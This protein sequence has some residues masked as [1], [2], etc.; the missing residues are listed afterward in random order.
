MVECAGKRFL[1][2]PP[3]PQ[4]KK[5]GGEVQT[6][7]MVRLWFDYVGLPQMPRTPALTR[8]GGESSGLYTTGASLWNFGAR[9]RSYEC[10]T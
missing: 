9:L 1:H 8:Q 6:V 10:Q 4:K 2:P 3:P 5:C 7:T